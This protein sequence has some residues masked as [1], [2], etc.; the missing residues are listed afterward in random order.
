MKLLL[1]RNVDQL[2]I[3]GDVVEVSAGYARNYLLPHHL[4]TEPTKAN[5]RKLAEARRVAEHERVEQRAVVERLA[6][7]IE[8]VEVTVR[9]K[10]NEEGHLYGSVGRREIAKALE[11][12]GHYIKPEHIQLQAPIRHLDTVTVDIRMA[13]DLHSSIK[14]WVVREKEDGEEG[15]AVETAERPTGEAEAGKEADT[16]DHRPDD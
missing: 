10:S 14:V 16:H 15:S 6:K 5:V 2:G 4:A 13:D 3:V 7:A 9:A 1:C 11:D 12:E 8:G